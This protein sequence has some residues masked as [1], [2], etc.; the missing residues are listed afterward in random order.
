MSSHPNRSFITP[1]PSGSTAEDERD[2]ACV[3]AL[4]PHVGRL[5]ERAIAAGWNQPEIATALLALV[6]SEMRDKAADRAIRETL[7]SAIMMLNE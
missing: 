3:K 6:V 1:P 7:A 2:D 4:A 5:A